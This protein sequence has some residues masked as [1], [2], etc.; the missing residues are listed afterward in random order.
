MKET[1]GKIVSYAPYF[2]E[3]ITAMQ[4]LLNEGNLDAEAQARLQQLLQGVHI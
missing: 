3:L 2:E 1:I 4:D